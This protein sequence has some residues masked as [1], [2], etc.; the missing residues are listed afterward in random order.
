MGKRLV[1]RH[2]GWR[3]RRCFNLHA[4][5]VAALGDGFDVPRRLGIVAQ[6]LPQ[7]G[8]RARQAVFT[9][10]Q[11]GPQ[12]GHQLFAGHHLARMRSQHEQ[13]VHDL[14]LHAH[15]SRRPGQLA[16]RA[17]GTPIAEPQ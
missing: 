13:Q 16:C 5:P 11:A 9:H 1:R 2:A 3:L 15:D 12:T 8:N 10:D 6:R 17:V 7:F 14:G 4:Q